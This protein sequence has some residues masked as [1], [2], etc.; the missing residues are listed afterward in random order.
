MAG[1]LVLGASGRMMRRRRWY[2]AAT[3]GLGAALLAN[4]RPYEGLVF[5][6]GVAV[7]LVWRLRVKLLR[8]EVIAPLAVVLGA[9]ALG[10]GAW[11]AQYTGNPAGDALPV[12]SRQLHGSSPFS[13]SAASAG[14]RLHSLDDAQLLRAPLSSRPPIHTGSPASRDGSSSSTVRR[15]ASARSANPQHVRAPAVPSR[16]GPCLSGRSARSKC[17]SLATT[18]AEVLAE[19]SAVL[20][21]SR[22]PR[23]GCPV[24]RA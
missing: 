3:L 17:A 4:S 10:T 5:T 19:R 12:L 6:A 15:R 22:S 16:Q 2:D 18:V 11:F 7:L 20:G 8:A 21:P 9:A 13:I 24:D 14:A 1:A 23:R